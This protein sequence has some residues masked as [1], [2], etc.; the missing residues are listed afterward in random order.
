MYSATPVFSYFYGTWGST[1]FVRKEAYF[2]KEKHTHFKEQCSARSS[3]CLLLIDHTSWMQCTWML[4]TFGSWKP[5]LC[6]ATPS[7]CQLTL[8]LTSSALVT[9]NGWEPTVLK[10]ETEYMKCRVRTWNGKNNQ[11]ALPW[12]CYNLITLHRRA[13]ITPYTLGSILSELLS[14]LMKC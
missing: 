10:M 7:Y 11:S 5:G 12:P 3:P 14:N 2:H 4:H 13:K 9:A 1:H 8:F 6:S